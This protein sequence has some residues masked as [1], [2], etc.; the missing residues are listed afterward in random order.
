MGGMCWD[1]WDA[2]GWV[3]STGMG[4][5]CWDRWDALGSVGRTGIHGSPHPPLFPPG[6][7]AGRSRER[8]RRARWAR[9][10]SS[11]WRKTPCTARGVEVGAGLGGEISFPNL[12]PKKASSCRGF[13]GWAGLSALPGAGLPLSAGHCWPGWRGH[14]CPF[15][16]EGHVSSAV[17]IPSWPG[18]GWAGLGGHSQPLHTAAHMSNPIF[19]PQPAWSRSSR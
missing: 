6:R 8:P 17:S 4:G 14:P 12:L 15:C 9:R 1:R 10:A 18:A 19:P 5:L 7:G 16:G 2:L 13:G 3:E 11:P